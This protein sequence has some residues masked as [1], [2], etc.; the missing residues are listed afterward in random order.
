MVLNLEIM[1][2]AFPSPKKRR[3]LVVE[4]HRF[5]RENLVTWIGRQEELECCGEAETAQ[6]AQS[7]VDTQQPDLL[8]LDLTLRGSTGFDLLRW[9]TARQ[10]TLPVIVLSQYEE[11]QYA[12]PVLEAGAR[13]YVSKGVATEELLPAINAVLDGHC[14]VSGRGAFP[15]GA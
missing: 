13:G 6:D 4:N 9:L 1:N 3:V 5:F 2:P 14:Y 8:L 12:T 7:A 10:S 11:A 15:P